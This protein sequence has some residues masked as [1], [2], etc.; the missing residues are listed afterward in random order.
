MTA[1][2]ARALGGELPQLALELAKLDS[3]HGFTPLDEQERRVSRALEPPARLERIV[4][5]LSPQLG[6]AGSV[7]VNAFLSSPRSGGSSD[8]VRPVCACSSGS[9]VLVV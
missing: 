9:G 3:T 7:H 2:R 1:G 4:D 8:R 6:K 5:H